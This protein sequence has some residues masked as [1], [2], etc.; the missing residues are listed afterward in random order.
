MWPDLT[1]SR[2]H[3]LAGMGNNQVNGADELAIQAAGGAGD[4]DGLDFHG[5]ARGG[6]PLLLVVRKTWERPMIAWPVQ[7]HQ[8]SESLG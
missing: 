6:E 5:G 8:E 7:R 2:D 1:D 4:R 3:H